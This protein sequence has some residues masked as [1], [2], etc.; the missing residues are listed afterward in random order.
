MKNRFPELVFLS[1]VVILIFCM[2]SNSQ[3]QIWAS[4]EEAKKWADETLAGLTL[5]KKVAQIIC[6]DIAGGYITKDDPTYKQWIRYAR[7][8]GIGGFVLYGGVE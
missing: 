5:E 3:A 6:T 8:Y 7:D 1:F 4:P 2:L